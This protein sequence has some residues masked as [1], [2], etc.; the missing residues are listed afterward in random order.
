MK[1]AEI[2]E[3]WLEDNIYTD[4][5]LNICHEIHSTSKITINRQRNAYCSESGPLD[6]MTLQLKMK[7]KLNQCLHL[8]LE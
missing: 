6:I 4:D 7:T 2:E 1:K 3:R 5:Q 8:P